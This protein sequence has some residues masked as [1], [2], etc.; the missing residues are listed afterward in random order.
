ML[1][2]FL[3]IEVSYSSS[4]IFLNQQKYIIDLLEHIGFTDCKPISTPIDQNH[5]LTKDKAA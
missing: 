3:G 4:G 5:K 2:Y 1:K